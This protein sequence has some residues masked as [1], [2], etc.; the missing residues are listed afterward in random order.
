MLAFKQSSFSHILNTSLSL[1]GFAP[2]YNTKKETIEKP[3]IYQAFCVI[4]SLIVTLVTLCGF[5]IRFY[6]IY[7]NKLQVIQI[8]IVSVEILFLCFI[9]DSIYGSAFFKIN[10]WNR[11]YKSYTK[12][13]NEL[14]LRI[15]HS[16]II[17]ILAIV[18]IITCNSITFNLYQTVY[19]LTTR[20]SVL[21]AYHQH[22]LTIIQTYRIYSVIESF[23]QKIVNINKRLDVAC[24]EK[25]NDN[26]A[27]IKI[28]SVSKIFRD[29]NDII[30]DFNQIFGSSIFL[31]ILINSSICLWSMS[32][33]A[34]FYYKIVPRR[35]IHEPEI[36][37][38]FYTVTI[39]IDIVRSN[40]SY[41]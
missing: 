23:I 8:L 18:T 33:T 32:E 22:I 1:V 35:E 40:I 26:L 10:S 34:A 36:V 37:M 20:I 15:G 29:T 25:I 12:L 2:Y 13:T 4:L 17:F 38:V 31:L 3:H 27:V 14:D 39:L 9:L 24:S 7:D 41:Y 21:M 6:Y 5:L 30:N 19:D 11:F 16:E 28:R